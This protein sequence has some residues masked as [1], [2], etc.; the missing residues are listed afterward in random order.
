MGK[1]SETTPDPYTLAVGERFHAERKRLG[2]TQREL[3]TLI[4]IGF[5]TMSLVDSGKRIPNVR[6]LNRFSDLG[7]DILYIITGTSGAGDVR[8]QAELE[9]KVEGLL[10][11]Q[12]ELEAACSDMADMLKTA[13]KHN[14]QRR[15]AIKKLK[16]D[17]L[18][19]T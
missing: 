8:Y 16:S 17:T 3:A 19:G 1:N 9:E 4:G 10:V 14:S 7:A 13:R 6:C 15:N 18:I 12:S 2:Y 5:V 11:L